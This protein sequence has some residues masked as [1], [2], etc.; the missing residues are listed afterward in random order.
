MSVLSV[1]CVLCVP[2][3]RCVLSVLEHDYYLNRDDHLN[4]D[5]HLVPYDDHKY[6]DLRE[7]TCSAKKFTTV[8]PTCSLLDPTSHELN[9]AIIYE[10][11]S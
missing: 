3:V 9:K 2:C 6:D 7:S 5:E 10:K 8:F 4:H 1:L 11:L